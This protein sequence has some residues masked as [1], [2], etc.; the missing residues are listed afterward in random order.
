MQGINVLGLT[1][2]LKVKKNLR[3]RRACSRSLEFNLGLGVFFLLLGMELY[4]LVQR[5]E[6]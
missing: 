5:C 1:I 3:K 2:N 6:L 4:H